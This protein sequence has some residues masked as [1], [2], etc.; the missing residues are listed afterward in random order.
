MTHS[1]F[2]Y[3]KN[4]SADEIVRHIQDVVADGNNISEKDFSCLI[5]ASDYSTAFDTVCRDYIYNF[6]RKMNFLERTISMIKNLYANALCKPLI[7]DININE[8]PV[9]SGVPQGCS[10]FG[11][12]FNIVMLPLL[13]KLNC[14]PL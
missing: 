8:F 10:L 6:L 9:T 14:L 4:K 1:Q 11:V 7:N 2:A 5:L 3:F 13:T 12:L